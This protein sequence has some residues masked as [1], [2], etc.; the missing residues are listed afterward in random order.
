VSGYPQ[1]EGTMR[2][3]RSTL[4]FLT[5]FALFFFSLQFAAAQAPKCNGTCEPDPTSSTYQQTVST[6]TLVAN[7]H[8]IG[9][10]PIRHANSTPQKTNPGSSS[11]SY[12][13]PVIHLPGRN[14]L[15]LDLTLYYNSHVITDPLLP[16]DDMLFV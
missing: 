5:L 12:P 13:L 2:V 10:S 16:L 11:Y 8:S 1:P 15:D 7:Q 4:R 6:R 3:A 14:G 9:P